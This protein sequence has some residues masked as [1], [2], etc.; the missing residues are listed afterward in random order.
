MKLLNPLLKSLLVTFIFLLISFYG[1]A[2]GNGI[3]RSHQTTF[4]HKVF[5]FPSTLYLLPLKLVN[6]Q[7][8]GETQLKPKINE[9]KI[10]KAFKEVPLTE[11]IK[12][13]YFWLPFLWL[14]FFFKDFRKPNNNTIKKTDKLANRIQKD[15][16]YSPPLTLNSI[17]KNPVTQSV[18]IYA[19]LLITSRIMVPSIE[20]IYGQYSKA[21]TYSGVGLFT[22]SGIAFIFYLNR[23]K[24]KTIDQTNRI[25]LV[26]LLIAATLSIELFFW[27]FIETQTSKL[28]YEYVLIFPVIGGLSFYVS[29]S[30]SEFVL[31]KIKPS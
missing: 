19:G 15:K 13:I 22:L 20:I 8:K 27:T 28:I 3:I 2:I 4:T 21:H 31:S 11:F 29:A 7:A 12:P 6:S 23:T 26:L 14:L 5:H 9:V 25:K 30:I 16:P 18:A 1:I 24:S 10:K 17:I